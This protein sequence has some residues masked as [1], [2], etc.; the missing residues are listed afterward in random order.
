MQK[1]LNKF[2]QWFKENQASFIIIITCALLLLWVFFKNSKYFD[3]L[4]DIFI[5]IPK[6]KIVISIVGVL[7]IFFILYYIYKY[8]YNKTKNEQKPNSEKNFLSILIFLICLGLLISDLKIP[9][10]GTFL[11][12]NWGK[13][14]I[15]ISVFIFLSYRLLRLWGNK[16]NWDISYS[17]IGIM[18]IILVFAFWLIQH[19]SGIEPNLKYKEISDKTFKPIVDESRQSKKD[20]YIGI[21]ISL[22]ASAIILLSQ[23]F[24]KAW[25]EEENN[26][27]IKNK[28]EEIEKNIKKISKYIETKTKKKKSPSKKSK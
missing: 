17:K 10:L 6:I 22:F 16:N 1:K 8:T 28:I 21:G 14:F 26:K 11:I 2:K 20:I 25:K 12:T 13:V 18:I 3:L 5:F 24:F 9:D 15:F 4:K 7:I 23:Y 27:E 19:G